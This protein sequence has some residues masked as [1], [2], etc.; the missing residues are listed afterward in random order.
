MKFCVSTDVEI[1]MNWSTFEPD[2]DHSPDA[3]TGKSEKRSEIWSRS[4][5][6]I[7]QSRLQ[8]TGCTAERYCLLHVVVQGPGS[9]RGRLAFLYDVRLRSYG[10]SKLPAQ[11][12]DF[13]RFSNTKRLK[14][15]FRC[16]I[17][18]QHRSY[19]YIAEQNRTDFICQMNDSDFS[20][21]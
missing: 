20:M 3:G 2:P 16:V 10:A 12:S 9:F 6:H 13:G 14:C 8:V 21:W 17:S 7:T 19:R 4:N 18:L 5:R 11:F 15:T 1:W